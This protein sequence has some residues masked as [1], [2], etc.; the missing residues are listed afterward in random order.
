MENNQFNVKTKNLKISLI[1]P[2]FNNGDILHNFLDSI[3]SQT[4]TELQIICINDG[5]NDN[6]LNI[7]KQYEKKDSRIIVLD[8]VKQGLDI[9]IKAGLNIALGDYVVVTNVERYVPPN[10]L[11]LEYKKALLDES[12]TFIDS[13]NS[14]KFYNLVLPIEQSYN[15]L[16]K[17][18][19]LEENDIELEFISESEQELESLIKAF[20]KY[21]EKNTTQIIASTGVQENLKKLATQTQNNFKIAQNAILDLQNKNNILN[22]KVISLEKQIEELWCELKNKT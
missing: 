14:K 16:I 18:S 1:I 3:I 17:T 9:A 22:Q 6:S 8:Q 12:K 19:Y 15:Q 21:N 10:Q 13:N 20:T 2:I 11:E 4:L 5:S 7:L